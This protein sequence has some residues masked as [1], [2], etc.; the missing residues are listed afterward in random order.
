MSDLELIFEDEEYE[1][2]FLS[3]ELYE[4]EAVTAVGSAGHLT[5]VTTLRAAEDAAREY[6]HRFCDSP[7]SPE[8][9]GFL[10]DA[11]APLFARCGYAAADDSPCDTV[12][13]EISGKTDAPPRLE[14]DVRLIW[15][16]D[17]EGEQYDFSQIEGGG[18]DGRCALVL[19][20]DTVLCAA[21]INDLRRDGYCEIYV[22][23]AEGHRRRGYASACV[24][25]LVSRLT[26][27]GQRVRY[28]TT[29]DNTASVALA[30]S[31]GFE[32][33]EHTASFFALAREE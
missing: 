19:S 17:G 29:A 11:L 15:C 22:E 24:S 25:L 20:G 10:S 28:E 9:K 23:C 16:G 27:A 26:E 32:E 5:S 30:R 14:D 4:A 31:L 2:A 6:A 13:F 7:F 3:G 18:D 8:A 21:G 1:R 12:A 33:L